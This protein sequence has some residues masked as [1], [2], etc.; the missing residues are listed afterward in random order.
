MWLN[1]M[2]KHNLTQN[3]SGIIRCQ[4]SGLTHS[5]T[6]WSRKGLPRFGQIGVIGLLSAFVLLTGCAT[7]P[8]V[9]PTQSRLVV[10]PQYYTVK[11]GDTLSK[12]AA[13]YNIDYQEVARLNNIN[14][15][16]TIYVNQSLRLHNG[17]KDAPRILV[18]ATPT[19]VPIQTQALQTQPLPQAK[20]PVAVQSN[21][22]TQTRPIPAT[23]RPVTSAVKPPVSTTNTATRAPVILPNTPTTLP[24]GVTWQWPADGAV[25]EQF[26]LAKEVKGVRIGGTTGT[27][28]RAAADGEVVYASDR[29]VEYGNLVLVRHSNGYVT[30]YAH[31]SKILVKEGDRVGAGQKIA[32][33]GASGTTKTMLEFQIRLNGKPVNPVVLL[34]SR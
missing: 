26:D 2:Q 13:R 34:P 15:D 4:F 30:A 28:I 32:E 17:G 16:Y 23:S 27:P 20:Q 24:G 7:K 25:L 29:L 1:D 10:I 3:Q 9:N 5:K 18:K 11:S 21:T 8:T 33:M 6:Y 12:I 22:V 31:N 19:A 14:S